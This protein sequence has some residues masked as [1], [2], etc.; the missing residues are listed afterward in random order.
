[1]TRKQL[2]E[3]LRGLRVT[4]VVAEYS[5]SGDEGFI[6]DIIFTGG[7]LPQA[8]QNDLN[9][10]FWDQLVDSRWSGF[11]DG[12][13]GGYGKMIWNIVT[14]RLG[15]HHTEYMIESKSHDEDIIEADYEEVE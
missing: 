1:M 3:T 8:T 7:T 14:D 6:D 13:P 9:D 12:E 2:L 4:E 10:F 5:G 11:W 15:V